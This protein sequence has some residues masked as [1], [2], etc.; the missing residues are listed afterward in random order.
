MLRR[1]HRND[2]YNI[3]NILFSSSPTWSNS[4]LIA[5][6]EPARYFP[7]ND[8]A[9]LTGATRTLAHYDTFSTSNGASGAQL[10]A[11]SIRT[12]VVE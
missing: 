1:T 4:F 7:R 3:G 2:G 6:D 8:S 10:P 5:L 11:L 12:F 9:W